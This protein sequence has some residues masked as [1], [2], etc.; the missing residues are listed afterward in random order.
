MINVVG[1]DDG[2]LGISVKGDIIFGGGG[3]GGGDINRDDGCGAGGGK[4]GGGGGEM[5]NICPLSSLS[6]FDECRGLCE[7]FIDSRSANV[8][9][10]SPND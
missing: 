10:I 7:V 1:P 4:R 9:M 8:A 5:I 6:S 2:V 3:G